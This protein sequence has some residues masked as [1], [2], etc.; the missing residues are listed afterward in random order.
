LDS[1][2]V[3]FSVPTVSASFNPAMISS[4]PRPTGFPATASFALLSSPFIFCPLELLSIK[5]EAS[6]KKM[7]FL[8]THLNKVL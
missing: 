1:I 6:K 5:S 3:P 4:L 7:Y 2:A 8:S